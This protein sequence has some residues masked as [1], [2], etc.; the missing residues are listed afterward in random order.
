MTEYLATGFAGLDRTG[1]PDV[2]VRC[3]R[4]LGAL[5]GMR[6]IK[7]ASLERL[8]LAPGAR[9]L[10]VGCG[11]GVEAAA[12]AQQVGSGVTG[13]PGGPGGTVGLAVGLDASQT[14]LGRA[15]RDQRPEAGAKPAFVVGEGARLPF[16]ANVFDACRIERTLQHV[17]DPGLVLA[18]MGRTTRP[19]GAV[20]AVEPDW[21]TFVV[22]SNFENVSRRLA[23][24]WC[25]SF[26]CGWIGRRLGRFMAEAGLVGVEIVPL[27]LVLRHLE[28]A[29]AVYSLLETADRAVA[30]GAVSL[31]EATAFAAEQRQRDAEGTFF[32]SLTFFMAVGYKP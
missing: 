25:D 15:A 32:S 2:Y 23:Q 8:A 9:V 17:P 30:D 5:P 18:E 11:L 4:Y 31:A 16:A 7:D 6:A 19:G 1:D 27:S 20:L 28:A 13:G 12:L 14:M 21:G 10:E 3:L 29:E 22:D 26:R 24:F